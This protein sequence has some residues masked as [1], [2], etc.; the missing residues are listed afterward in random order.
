[1]KLCKYHFSKPAVKKLK[2]ILRGLSNLIF[3]R[4]DAENI[5][6][7]RIKLFNF[8]SVGFFRLLIAPSYGFKVS[9]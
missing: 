1:M 2:S 7:Q 3:L 6:S 8:N 5:T 4:A 9:F